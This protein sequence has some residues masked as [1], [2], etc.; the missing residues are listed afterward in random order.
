MVRVGTM[1]ALCDELLTEF[2]PAYVEAGM[3]LIDESN[4]LMRLMRYSPQMKNLV[5]KRMER[6]IEKPVNKQSKLIAL[7]R[8]GWEDLSWP[9]GDVSSYQRVKLV[10]DVIA[11]TSE[12]SI[13][14]GVVHSG[15]LNG[16]DFQTP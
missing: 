8:P 3:Q 12:T 15:K 6:L 10:H 11:S 7:F 13:P 16:L 1:H 4:A 2:D 5:R 9:R 14:R